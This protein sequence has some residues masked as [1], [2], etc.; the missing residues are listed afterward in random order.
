M[1][2]LLLQA[3]FVFYDCIF[4]WIIAFFGMIAL[5]R[6]ASRDSVNHSGNKVHGVLKK[7]GRAQYV[8]RHRTYHGGHENND[9]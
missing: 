8:G 3:C 1:P 5:T 9:T 2:L 6:R 7:L 4:S